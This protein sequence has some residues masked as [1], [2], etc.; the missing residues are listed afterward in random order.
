M[1]ME[2]VGFAGAYNKFLVYIMIIHW[3]GDSNKAVQH[4]TNLFTSHD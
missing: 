3:K 4:V 2:L 1:T